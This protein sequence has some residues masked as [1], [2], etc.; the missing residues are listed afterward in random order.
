MTA[1][2]VL[3]VFCAG[4]GGTGGSAPSGGELTLPPVA[5]TGASAPPPPASGGGIRPGGDWSTYHGDPTRAGYDR[6]GPDPISPAVAWQAPLDGKVYASPLVVGGEVVAATEN[7]SLYGLDAASGAVRWRTHLAD[8]VPGSALPCGDIDPVGITGTPVADPATGL[9]YTVTTQT[10]AGGGVEHVLWSVDAATGQVRTQRQV[11]APGADPTT[12]LQRGALLLANHTVYLAYG[13]NYGDCGQYLGRV[14]GV[15][16]TGDGPTTAFAVP[17]TREGGIWA[18]AGPAALPDGNLLIT[19]G[20]G[21]AESGSWDHS[22][23]I[24][25]LSP[26]LG[27]LDGFAPTQWAQENSEDADLGSTG[28]VILPDGSGV[29]AAGKGGGVYLA[30]AA[31]LGGVGGQRAQLDNC[32]AYGGGAVAP[33]SGGGAVAYLPC[34]TGLLQVRVP[35][36]GQL[37]RGWQAPSQITGS[38]I[39]V[40]TTVWSLQQDG[41][42]DGLDAATGAVR[43]SL[44]AGD[45]TRFATPAASGN[46]LYL[47]T[48]HGI[49]AVR[50]TN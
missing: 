35:G 43:A 16:A 19:T 5:S 30:D 7:G 37:V 24:L 1:A 38:P 11:D 33:V 27:L 46:A 34:S 39:L 14:V 3:L 22:D 40:G 25:R 49:T 15:P 50:I 32:E 2:A 4:C 18:A 13:G 21:E 31:A 26:Q 47:P 9:V 6:A 8:P 20:N 28:P 29:I 42:L 12:H 17:T 41:V 44:S 23:S 36:P 48:N 10:A 45:A